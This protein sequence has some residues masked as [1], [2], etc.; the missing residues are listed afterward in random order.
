MKLRTLNIGCFGGGTGLPS[1]LGGL[2]RNPWLSLNAVVTMFDSGGSSGVLRDELGVL[3]PGDVLKCALALARNERE[4]RRVLLSRLPTLEHARL[5]G[6]TGGN[7]LLSMMERYC[8]DFVAAVDGLRG[9]LGCAGRV[10][11]VSVEQ[12]SVCAEYQDGSQTRGEVEVDAGQSAG[13]SVTRLWLEPEV[14]L[15]PSTAA[16]IPQFEAAIIGPGSFYTSLMPIFLVGGAPE[17][18]RQVH[19]PII[20]VTNLLTE[21]WGMSAFTAGTAVRLLSQMLGRPIDVALVNTMYPSAETLAKYAK[22]H[23]APLEVGDVPSETEVVCGEFWY[24]DIARHDR[25]RLAHAVWAVLARRL[26]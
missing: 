10:W 17:A 12:A 2:K 13:H 16:A 14:K 4:A 8:G 18:I 7:L 5:G 25:R 11:P 15:H 9:L 23:K 21:G 20:L 26:L 6:H 22:E 3:P 19:G 1:L 24:G